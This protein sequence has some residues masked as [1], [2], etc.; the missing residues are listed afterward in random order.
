MCVVAVLRNCLLCLGLITLVSACDDGI[1]TGQTP[2]P[3]KREA[4]SAPVR[5]T[6]V[7]KGVVSLTGW[8]GKP[9]PVQAVR[10]LGSDHDVKIED[11]SV[12][13][14]SDGRLRDVVVYLKDADK[15]DGSSEPPAVLDQVNCR[16]V[17]H[18]V[19]VQVGQTLRVKS[20]D[21]TLHNVHVQPR[22]N[23][24][25]NFGMNGVAMRDLK[26]Q[27]PERV[28]V[29]CDVHPWMNAEVVVVENPF[30]GVSATDGTF[31]ITGVPAGDYT[32][33]ASHGRLGELERKVTVADEKPTDARFEYKPPQ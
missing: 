31:E 2:S 19:A 13:V 30:V 33:V 26:F 23:A 1:G 24:G 20:S 8:T 22:D 29:R 15:S 6:G 3:M 7:I 11:E 17:P 27:A 9:A 5:G 32:L 21:E 12:V 25:V 28:R 10:C 16:Y 14:R 18:V 4:R